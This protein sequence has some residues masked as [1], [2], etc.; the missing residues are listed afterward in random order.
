MYLT[1]NKSVM[2]KWKNTDDMSYTETKYKVAD[3]NST[4]LVSTLNIN[5]LNT[6]IKRINWLNGYQNKT[7]I[8]TVYKRSP[9]DL[10]THPDWKWG[11]R[12]RYSMQIEI[13]DDWSTNTRIRQNKT[14][15]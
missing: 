1:Q 15:K 2:E 11:N 3:V 9:S 7:N 13:K 10:G 4:L 14:L 8:Y 6:P 12:K 5:G